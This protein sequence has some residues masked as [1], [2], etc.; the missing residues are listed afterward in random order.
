LEGSVYRLDSTLNFSNGIALTPDE[1]SLYVS[2]ARSQVI[3]LYNIENDSTLA[4]KRVFA[5]VPDA[6][7]LD[8]M[9]VDENGLLYVAGGGGVWIFSTEGDLVDHLEMS[10]NTTNLAWGDSTYQ[11]L[12]ITQITD[13]FRIG[14]N[15]RGFVRTASEAGEAPPPGDAL[16]RQNYPNPFNSSTTITY[17]LSTPTHVE[18]TIH[19]QLGQT[20]YA[21]ERAHRSIGTHQAVW[22]GNDLQGRPAASGV[23]LY[24]LRIGLSVQTQI[25]AL[26]R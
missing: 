6:R 14:V 21:L 8:G 10:G 13:I 23:Y 11:T 19:N 26:V 4:N 16:L 18:L 24:T 25:M 15:A 22:N 3:Y 9:K 17:T 20:V 12:Y 2:A 7:Y 5:S 1:Q